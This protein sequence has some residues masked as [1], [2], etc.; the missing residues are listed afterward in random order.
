MRL[1][2]WAGVAAIAAVPAFALAVDHPGMQGPHRGPPTKAEA[3]KRAGDMFD[4]LDGDHDGYVT[5]AE[6]DA[7]RARMR[8]GMA[9]GMKRMA[10]RAFAAIDADRNGQ[11]S[12]AEFDAAHRPGAMMAMRDVPPPPVQADAPPPPPGGPGMFPPPGMAMHGP[13]GGMMMAAMFDRIDADHDG[14]ISRAEAMRAVDERFAR[15]DTNGDGIIGPDE[16][17]RGRHG[18]RKGDGKSPS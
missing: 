12:R 17:G 4:T 10:D 7:A 2:V 9:A 6:A 3:E 14:R 5:R 16:G 1:A 18:W 13:M 15:R 11:I 8:A